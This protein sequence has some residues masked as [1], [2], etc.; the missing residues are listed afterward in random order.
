MR[1][2]DLF[3]IRR[4][5]RRVIWF[6]LALLVLF[7]AVTYIFDVIGE[8]QV[9]EIV[10]ADSTGTTERQIRKEIRDN[11][12]YYNDRAG[13][14]YYAVES[15][16]VSRFPFDPNTADST[17]LLALGLQPFQVR[18]IYRY[19]AKGGVYRRKEDFARLYG[20]TNK[21]YRELEPYITIG[22]DYQPYVVVGEPRPRHVNIPE[23]IAA[24]QYP[25]KLK[26]GEKIDLNLADTTQLMRVPGIGSFYARQIYNR[27]KWLGG[28]YTEDQLLEIEYFPKE[29]INYFFVSPGSIKKL[30]INEASLQE[31]KRH[32][33]INYYQARD[34]VE[35]RRQRGPI[36]NIDE[37]K[38][39]KDFT[40]RDL[41]KIR[42]Y[43]EY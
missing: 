35:Y 12:H 1:F 21:Q 40:E 11:E 10:Q 13:G 36:K 26:A 20:L 14:G 25:Q 43:V 37:L 15:R 16:T 33:Y 38:L 41:E 19:R 23:S 17:Q 6:L 39:L 5:D 27:R 28:F 32:P 7:L 30:R 8:K 29:A 3:Y 22:K 34:I 24:H 9:Q 18:N 4:S 2:G 31:L 42:H